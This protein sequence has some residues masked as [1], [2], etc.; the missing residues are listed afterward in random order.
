T[1]RVGGLVD[2]ARDPEFA[3]ALVRAMRTGT[4]TASGGLIFRAE[5]AA[6]IEERE[7]VDEARARGVE[8]S[9]VSI[10]FGDKGLLKIYRRLRPG[11]QPDIEV[12]RFLTV[13]A[14]YPNTP[15]FLGEATIGCEAGEPATVAACFAFVPNQG[16]GWQAMVDA[17]GRE[18][19]DRALASE[20]TTAQMPA[21]E[22]TH[23]PERQGQPPENEDAFPYPLDLTRILG[24]RTGELH[25]AFAT[26]TEDPAF[27]LEPV[28]S[29]DI[30]DWAADTRAQAE[31]AFR[32]IR[33]GEG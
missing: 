3:E 17:L 10:A 31:D 26:P 23:L 19:E 25:A 1:N 30:A 22:A 29:E 33:S 4:E 9:N 21:E 8:Q 7:E 32:R 12:G 16:D 18:L 5:G 6:G 24:Q 15:A 14:D 20:P 2:A 11:R 13:I 27:A 28:T